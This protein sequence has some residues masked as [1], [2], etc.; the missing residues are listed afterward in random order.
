LR[1]HIGFVV[2]TSVSKTVAWPLRTQRFKALLK[3]QG[4]FAN[5]IQPLKAVIRSKGQNSNS[6]VLSGDRN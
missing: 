5:V 3:S 2:A 4:K 6:L 1:A